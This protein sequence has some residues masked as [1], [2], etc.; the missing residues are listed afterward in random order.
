MI[1]PSTPGIRPRPVTVRPNR[2]RT[3][4]VGALVAWAAVSGATACGASSDTGIPAAT[5]QTTRFTPG[6]SGANAS[7]PNPP[8]NGTSNT[9]T[10][11][12]TTR[13]QEDEME[14]D[15]AI[16]TERF[17]ASLTD[18]AASRDLVA[19]LPLTLQMRDH[20][21]VEKTGR[22]PAPLSLE[23]QPDGADPDP[24]QVGYY[25]PGNDLVLYYGDQ[26]YFPGIVLL[27][28]LEDDAAGRLAALEGTVTATVSAT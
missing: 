6:T 1:P 8:R 20:G 22:L 13:E 5:S 11:S 17:R 2:T 24:G 18:S 26:S 25:A 7:T 16:G 12:S 27:G 23:G 19:Q 4:I 28:R 15:I 10:L 21:S 9:P 14:I 3:R